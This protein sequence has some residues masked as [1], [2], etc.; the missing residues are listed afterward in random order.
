MDM[1]KNLTGGN[2][3]KK[4]EVQEEQPQ[5]SSGGGFMDKINSMAGG[6]RESEK[7]EDMLDK[8]RLPLARVPPLHSPRRSH[9]STCFP[10]RF[11]TFYTTYEC[12]QR[13]L[14]LG[15]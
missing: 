6:G 2:S 14:N 3:E 13:R 12:T 9:H 11:I 10:L 5:S 4:P 7:K 8:L 1:L 15:L